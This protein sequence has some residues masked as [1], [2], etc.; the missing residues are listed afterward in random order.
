MAKKPW[1]IICSQCALLAFALNASLYAQSAQGSIQLSV[2][3]ARNSTGAILYSLFKDGKGYPDQP[4]LAY[5]KGRVAIGKEGKVQVEIDSLL[6]GQ[7]AIALLHDENG[8]NKMNTSALGL[9]KEGYGFSNNVMG[10]FGPPSFT[11]ASLS[12]KKGE[13]KWVRINLRY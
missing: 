12:L 10:L 1:L 4:A 6:P 8:D 5:Y 13:R 9:P 2:G 3:G 7:Y 11:K